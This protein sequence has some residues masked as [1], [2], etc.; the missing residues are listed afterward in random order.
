MSEFDQKMEF[1]NAQSIKP[2]FPLLVF[3]IFTDL[4]LNTSGQCRGDLK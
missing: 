2:D 4:R 1:L 3:N